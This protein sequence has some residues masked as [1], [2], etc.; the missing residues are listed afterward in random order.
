M[1]LKNRRAH[2]R[3]ASAD[4]PSPAYVRIPNLP[5]VSLVD[6]SL[7]GALLEMPFQLQPASNL[8]LELATTDERVSIPFQLLRC[9]VADIKGAVRYHAAGAFDSRFKLP[10]SLSGDLTLTT[11]DRLMSTLETFLRS[12]ERVDPASRGA[13]FN[14]LL[15]WVVRML[16]RGEAPDEISKQLRNYLVELFPTL[17]IRR[18]VPASPIEASSG[19][20]RFFDLDFRSNR[21]LSAADRRF[22]RASAQLVSL[23]D[24]H[25]TSEAAPALAALVQVAREDHTPR[26]LRL[27]DPW[28]VRRSV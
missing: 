10:R 24:A 9:S 8:T 23:I 25:S 17:S 12:G 18:A 26:D 20:I 6:L 28:P 3:I 13:R 22:L 15:E 5:A 19:T 4:L 1:G 16:Q 14:G 2:P 27:V 21:P 11:P 7:G